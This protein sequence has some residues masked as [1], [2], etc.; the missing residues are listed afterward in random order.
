MAILHDTDLN[1][2]HAPACDGEVHSSRFRFRLHRLQTAAGADR[3][4][5]TGVR[6]FGS[7]KGEL[8]VP[9]DFSDLPKEIDD[10]FYK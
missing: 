9:D 10:L 2:L 7:A 1:A 6:I 8:V 5:R 4:Y 3:L